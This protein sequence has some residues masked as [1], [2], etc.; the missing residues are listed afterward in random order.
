MLSSERINWDFFCVL[1]RDK[2]EVQAWGRT[3]K[4]KVHGEKAKKLMEEFYQESGRVISKGNP[5]YPMYKLGEEKRKMHHEAAVK[6]L[7]V[8]LSYFLRSQKL[9]SLSERA[10]SILPAAAGP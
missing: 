7:D 10:V 5:R 4:K 3:G 2:Q 6:N 8:K 9:I 1:V